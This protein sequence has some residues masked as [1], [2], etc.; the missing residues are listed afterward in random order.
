MP[1]VHRTLVRGPD[2]PGEA[3]LLGLHPE[4]AARIGFARLQH[5]ALTRLPARADIYCF[6]GRSHAVAD[7]E[8]IFVLAE[9][10]G[11]SATDA[12]ASARHAAAFERVFI[13]ATRALRG[14]RDP[15]R[16][17]HWNRIT[18]TVAPVLDLGP[19]AIEGIAQRLAPATRH[20]GL[21]KVVARL[22]LRDRAR[23]GT[24]EPVELV[25]SDLT[26]SHMEIAVRR[27]RTSPLEP[28]SMRTIS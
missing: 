17:L 28:V 21:E 15:R 25:V 2:G 7:D 3:A 19:E 13:Q 18:I 22:R 11:R 24:A 27:P 16:R 6:H 14:A 8:R 10:R 9:V 26:G 5:F 23:D 20:L 1:D 12:Q 4:T